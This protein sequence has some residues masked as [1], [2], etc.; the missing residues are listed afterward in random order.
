MK[1]H[2]HSEKQQTGQQEL[3]KNQ[4]GMTWPIINVVKIRII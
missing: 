4:S 3:N 2:R 1:Q